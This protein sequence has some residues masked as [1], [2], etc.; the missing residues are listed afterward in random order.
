VR[1][2]ELMYEL[3]GEGKLVYRLTFCFR[4]DEFCLFGLGGLEGMSGA[5]DLSVSPVVGLDPGGV[6]MNGSV[7][8]GLVGRTAYRLSLAC[9][10]VGE[11]LEYGSVWARARS[12][13]NTVSA[14]KF[15][16]ARVP[17]A[18]MNAGARAA[19]LSARVLEG[20]AAD[21]RIRTTVT[22]SVVRVR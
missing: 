1:A 8:E 20:G 16:N 13:F 15:R 7:V 12:A 10:I 5:S 9:D 6:L 11:V 21:C 17:K 4:F 14:S 19:A 22:I 3:G 2:D 18:T